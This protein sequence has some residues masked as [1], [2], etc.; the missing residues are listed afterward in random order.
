MPDDAGYPTPDELEAIACWDD[1]TVDGFEK[2]FEYIQQLWYWSFP[3]I[4]KHDRCHYELHTG[5]WSGNEDIICAMRNN[6]LLWALS[7]E[8]ARR[9]GHYYF[10]LELMPDDCHNAQNKCWIIELSYT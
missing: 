2:L 10:D 6:T 7:W 9:G 1:L 4:V 8:C 5:G 3:Y